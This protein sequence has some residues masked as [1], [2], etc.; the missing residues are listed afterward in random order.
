MSINGM[1]LTALR[2][3]ADAEDVRFAG[4]TMQIHDVHEFDAELAS[5]ELLQVG[6]TAV[7][8]MSGQLIE[9]AKDEL[10]DALGFA[11]DEIDVGVERIATSWG[12]VFVFWDRGRGTLKAAR[13]LVAKNRPSAR[14]ET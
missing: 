4:G 6:F 5:R 2:A 3:A 12:P 7:D 14:S 13:E 11:V 1:Q 10:F 9:C 8:D